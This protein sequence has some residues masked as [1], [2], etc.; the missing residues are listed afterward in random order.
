MNTSSNYLKKVA[1][2]SELKAFYNGSKTS[3][4]TFG[5]FAVS[6]AFLVNK[7]KDWGYSFSQ[8]I[9]RATAILSPIAIFLKFDRPVVNFWYHSMG[10]TFVSCN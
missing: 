9:L 5:I 8:S 2:F 3:A 10:L 7:F 4:A 1:L 6:F